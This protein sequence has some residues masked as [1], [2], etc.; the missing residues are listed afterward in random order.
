MRMSAALS[1]NLSPLSMVLTL[2]PSPVEKVSLLL[3]IFHSTSSSVSAHQS[4][5]IASHWS[6]LLWDL[7]PVKYALNVEL[8]TSSMVI[9]VCLSVLQEP[10]PSLTKMEV[11]LAELALVNLDSFW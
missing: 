8:K 4:L 2:F 1:I 7:I 11:L 10:M 9:S 6:M 5:L 3:Q